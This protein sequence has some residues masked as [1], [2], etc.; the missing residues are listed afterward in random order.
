[1]PLEILSGALLAL[2]G[3]Y[4]LLVGAAAVGLRRALRRPTRRLQAEPPFV[5]VIVPARDEATV[6][7]ACLSSIFAAG[8]PDDRFEVI[9]VDDLSNDATP[10]IV[11]RYA[12]RLRARSGARIAVLADGSEEE[13]ES[14]HGRLRLLRMPENLERS[15]AHKKRAIE[16]GVSHARGDLI[17]TTD[18]DCLVPRGW[19]GTMAACFDDIDQ[20]PDEAR[21]TAFVSGPVLYRVEQ[22]PVMQMQALE[23]L[24][25]VSFGAGVIGLGH[26]VTCNGANV[27]YRR[28]VFESLGGFSGIDHLTS[29]DDELLMQKVARETPHRVRFCSAR[30]AAVETDGIH[31]LRGFLQQR[32]RWASKG[33]HYPSA[34]LVASLAVVY[35]FHVALVA[36]ALATPFWPVL[37]PAV[38][39]ALA[40]DFV[41][42]AAL[43]G[44]AA[45]H[46]DRTEL[47]VWLVPTE[48]L[49]LPYFVAIGIA[50]AFGGF[51]WKGRRVSR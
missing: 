38:A 22:S 42:G 32:R 44:Q 51:E 15:R 21:V 13:P 8:Y 39:F 27:A 7:D 50:G 5:T 19:I 26:P 2:A 14:E 16:K 23:F 41:A 36:A 24:G 35:L 20:D 46:F 31:T 10:A 48:I 33:M 37:A 29:G 40:L 4:A 43:A 18:A 9:V 12:A 3:V 25:L 47:L 49:R 28:D 11:E 6:I 30:E 34:G 17:L 45:V 1:M